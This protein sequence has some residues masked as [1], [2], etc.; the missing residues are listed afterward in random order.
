M[1]EEVGAVLRDGKSTCAKCGGVDAYKMSSE[2]ETKIQISLSAKDMAAAH[3]INFC[4]DEIP[5]STR[6]HLSNMIEIVSDLEQQLEKERE[7]LSEIRR[8]AD[9]RKKDFYTGNFA[10]DILKIIDER[11]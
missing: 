9:N 7:K 11:F 8:E 3:L 4:A 2:R 10:G 5:K 6:Q 1:C